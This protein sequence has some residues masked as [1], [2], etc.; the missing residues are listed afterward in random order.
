MRIK[1]IIVGLGLT[2][3]PRSYEAFRIDI[4]MEADLEEGDDASLATSSLRKIVSKKLEQA[5][6]TEIEKLYGKAVVT[7][8]LKDQATDK[9]VDSMVRRL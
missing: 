6:E 4:T 3:Q 7:K 1:R 8:V 5:I 2:A 9:S